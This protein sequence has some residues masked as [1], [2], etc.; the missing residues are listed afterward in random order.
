ME[1]VGVSG[2][3]KPSSTQT[4]S[5]RQLNRDE[6]LALPPAI[7]VKTCA[8]AFGVHP[9]TMYE[10]LARDDCPL[11]VLRIGRKIRVRTV[12]VW[13]H[14]GLAPAAPDAREAAEAS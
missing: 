10:Y 4:A 5:A 9:T 12:S 14:L 13:R 2:S 6:I 1:P 3:R 11:S 7:G 8:Q